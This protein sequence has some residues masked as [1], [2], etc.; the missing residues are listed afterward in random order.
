MLIGI[1][2]VVLITI[3]FG[4]FVFKPQYDRFSEARSNQEKELQEQVSKKNELAELKMAK[5]DAAL[6]EAQ[7]LSLSK[8]MPEEADLSSIL[9]ELDNLGRETNVKVLDITPSEVTPATGY[10]TLPVELKVVG[11]Y[12]NLADFT[13]KLVKLP[14]EYTLGDISVEIAEQGYPLLSATI[15]TNTFVYSPT[16]SEASSTQSGTTSSTSQTTGAQ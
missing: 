12:F 8:R 6:T 14:R 4:V 7:S 3:I 5:K 16:A 15:K 13:Y 9:V 1:T 2:L 10:S 11:T